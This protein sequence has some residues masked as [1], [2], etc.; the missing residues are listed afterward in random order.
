MH[1]ELVRGRLNLRR[2]SSRLH[3]NGV[4]WKRPNTKKGRRQ[5]PSALHR[6]INE[7]QPPSA[8]HRK[9]NERQPPSALHRERNE[10]QPPSALHRKRNAR[11]RNKLHPKAAM[12]KTEHSL[13]LYVASLFQVTSPIMS[14]NVSQQRRKHYRNAFQL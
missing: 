6:E 13:A 10:R 5:L 12:T 2:A 14:C 9:R 8:L 11:Q 4:W 1:R 3:T 7:R